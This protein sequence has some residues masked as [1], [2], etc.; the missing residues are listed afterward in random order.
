MNISL[1]HLTQIAPSSFLLST[2]TEGGVSRKI[3]KTYWEP[4]IYWEDLIGTFQSAN[5]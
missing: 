2:G 4:L 5:F 3:D 1:V